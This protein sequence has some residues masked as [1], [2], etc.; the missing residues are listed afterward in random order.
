MTTTDDTHAAFLP[1]LPTQGRVGEGCGTTPVIK[2]WRRLDEAARRALLARP[3][4]ANRA[5]LRAEIAETIAQVRR[6]GDAALRS[7]TRRFDAVELQR[8]RVPDDIV[9][10]CAER[11]PPALRAAIDRAAER[12]AAFHAACAPTTVAVETAPGVRCER[13]LRP[14]ERAGLYVPAGTAPLPSTALMLAVPAQLAGVR[15]VVLCSPP[16]ADGGVDDAVCYV[17]AR[18]GV[19]SVFAIGGAQAIAAMAYGTASVPRCDKLFG[20]GSARVDEAK[21]LVAADAD[22]AAIDLPAGPSELLVI[23][24]ASADPRYV[25]A[26][27]LSQAEH[28][29]DSQVILLSDDDALLAAVATELDRQLAALPRRA[30]AECALAHA[31]LLRVASLGDAVAIANDYAPEHLAL[32]VEDPRALL[33][34]V[35]AAGSVFLGRWSPEAIG[36]YASGTNHVLPTG[37]AA[38]GSNGVSIA[39]FLRAITVQCLTRRGLADIGPDAVTIA[40]AEGLEAHARAVAIRLQGAA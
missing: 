5:Q 7:L 32:Q 33:T 37:G 36:D 17:A 8:I 26:D 29:A 18:Y 34:A 2:D 13:I 19:V 27:L 39:S 24:D 3:A 12:I 40:R 10:A 9:A 14:L 4:Q 31:R 16:R 28:G 38:R 20:P 15:E 30:V 11:V 1:P 35:R 23:A 22:G 6:D 25:A 21:R